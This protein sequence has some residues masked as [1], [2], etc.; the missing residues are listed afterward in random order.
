MSYKVEPE[1]FSDMMDSDAEFIP[2]LTIEGRLGPDE[3]VPE[4][5]PILPLRNSVLYP[6]V[7]IPITV[8]RDKSIQLVKEYY[9]KRK[10]IGVIAQKESNVDEPTLEDL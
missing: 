9:R 2:V 6:G 10:S 5:L 4:E 8:G 1:L 3:E 7:V